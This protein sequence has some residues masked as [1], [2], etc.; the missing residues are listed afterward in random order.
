VPGSAS[1]QL[2]RLVRQALK[3]GVVRHVG[4]GG[5]IWSNVHIDDVAE[6]YRL[7]L[8]AA[9]RHP[10]RKRAAARPV[11][12]KI[13]LYALGNGTATKRAPSAV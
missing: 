11:G 13:R 12:R 6:L 8:E 5:N 9:A 1:V 4:S 3:S 2:P 10:P 7:A